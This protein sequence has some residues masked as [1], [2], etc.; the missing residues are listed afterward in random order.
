MPI[1]IILFIIFIYIPL[2]V[3]FRLAGY[4]DK[5]RYVGGRKSCRVR[6]GRR[7]RKW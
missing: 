4:N 7:R 5:G 2:G 6:R 1:L 3:I